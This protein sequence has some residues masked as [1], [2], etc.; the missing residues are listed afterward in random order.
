M[1]NPEQLHAIPVD[2]AESE[3]ETGEAPITTEQGENGRQELSIED[4][5]KSVELLTAENQEAI[6]HL[7]AKT[8]Q[9]TEELE[10]VRA[11]LGIPDADSEPTDAYDP[12]A[13]GRLETLQSEQEQLELRREELLSAQEKE[14]LIKQEKEK[15]LQE[16]IDGLFEEFDKALPEVLASLSKNGKAPNGEKYSSQDL[17]ELSPESAQS[18]AQA[19]KEGLKLLPEIL[20]AAPEALKEFDG[21]ITKEAEARVEKRIEKEKAALK[22]GPVDVETEENPENELEDG[23]ESGDGETSGPRPSTS[24]N[25]NPPA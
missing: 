2:P 20:K 1:S 24:G 25:Q 13:K 14:Q 23:K 16:K 9:S 21:Q 6:G 15:I 11:R 18:L 22:E 19:F 10:G 4:R 8:R 12:A 3:Q 5:L 17:G 7:E